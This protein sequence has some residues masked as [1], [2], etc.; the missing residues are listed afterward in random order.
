[1]QEA[2]HVVSSRTAAQGYFCGFAGFD[3]GSSPLLTTG[4][5]LSLSIFQCP[6][7]SEGESRTKKQAPV[8]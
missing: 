5:P 8:K 1:M 7:S 4:H 3:N 6:P 2:E